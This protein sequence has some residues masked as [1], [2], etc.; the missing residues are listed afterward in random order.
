MIM[1][2]VLTCS[3]TPMD[4][5]TLLIKMRSIVVKL[6]PREAG[7]QSDGGAEGVCSGPPNREFR[8]YRS[9]K[10]LA[11]A[12]RIAASDDSPTIAPEAATIRT[13]DGE[14]KPRRRGA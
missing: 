9:A 12:T 3:I 2:P 11:F 13:E 1:S 7:R 8:I 10:L 6:D 4:E 14:K 5:S